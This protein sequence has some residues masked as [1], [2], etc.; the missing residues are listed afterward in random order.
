MRWDCSELIAGD[1][2]VLRGAVD[3]DGLLDASRFT[4]PGTRSEAG[5]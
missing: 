2:E 3:V 5:L 1:W 4:R